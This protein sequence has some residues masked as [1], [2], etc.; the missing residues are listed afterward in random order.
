MKASIKTVD[1]RYNSTKA[2]GHTLKAL[3]VANV[4]TKTYLD[5]ESMPLWGVETT[6]FRQ[7]DVSQLWGLIDPGQQNA[8]NLT[9]IRSPR[10]YLPGWGGLLSNTPSGLDNLPGV[11]G[12][13]SALVALYGSSASS[14]S[15]IY[16]YSGT[17]NYALLAKWRE[18]SKSHKTMATAMN[19]IWTDIAANYLMGSR[20]WNTKADWLPPN[21][22]D[23]TYKRKRQAVSSQDEDGQTLVPMQVYHRT[24]R[25]RWYFAI[26]AAASLLL[27]GLVVLGA[28]LLMVFGKGTPARINHFL[29]HLSSGRLLG[30]M[31]YPSE[32]KD[33]PTQEWISRVGRKESD[34]YR[35]SPAYSG[36]MSSGLS[37]FFGQSTGYG[38]K[39]STPNDD[40]DT[41][42]SQPMP[43]RPL[44]SGGKGYV[45]V[46]THDQRVEEVDGWGR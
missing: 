14:T 12:P 41:R 37:P 10:L 1:F 6:N 27:M 19:L 33:A 38:E 15:G 22:Q 20:S 31:Q 40:Y 7:Q 2:T 16:D 28:L 8:P 23:P 3:T 13:G 4:T 18:Y 44:S 36:E 9:T 21:L 5:N 26:P 32:D 39:V 25:Y 46:N 17:T 30:S 34:L 11:K 24:I 29:V 43:M 45:Q 42:D 35:V